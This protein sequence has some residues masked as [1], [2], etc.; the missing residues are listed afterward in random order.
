MFK[1]KKSFTAAAAAALSL[2]FIPGCSGG[3][4][5]ESETKTEIKTEIKTEDIS[6]KGGAAESEP[7]TVSEELYK[8]MKKYSLACDNYYA[9]KKDE[10]NFFSWAGLL[11][12]YD[13]DGK[14]GEV[15]SE[16]IKKAGY[17]N[18][19]N[20][21]DGAFIL[22]MRPSDI[23]ESFKKTSLSIFSAV[24]TKEGYIVS[25][26]GF[27]EKLIPEEAFKEIMLKYNI[28]N[29]KTVNP[30][31]GL[32]T[33]NSIMKAIGA[34]RGDLKENGEF[35]Y[36]VRYAVNNDLYAVVILSG[37]DDVTDT[38]QYLL[39]KE[40]GGWHVAENAL[41]NQE[42]IKGYLN[43]KYTDFDLSL[44]PPYTLYI[45]RKEVRTAE[46]YENVIKA[47]KEQNILND[48]DEITYCCGTQH[49]LYMEL[50]S[51][52]KL[53]GG[54]KNDG[55]FSCNY[56]ETYEDAVKELAKFVEPVP[57]FILKYNH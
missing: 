52:K 14:I 35:D 39:R 16:M 5:E 8:K 57:A 11:A 17:L 9:K 23:D 50:K 56:V 18:S 37:A 22:Y 47:L 30:E 53:A 20:T 48:S 36:I 10:M 7:L 27:G 19:A 15:S 1:N 43:S 33:Y 44:L 2:C 26:T 25:G 46:H 41:E 21:V 28:D 4:G 54:A 40:E 32:E 38:T 29:G 55:S 49:V 31:T 3:E 24:K 34:F 13:E 51:G 45:Y 42:D 6:E 12:Y